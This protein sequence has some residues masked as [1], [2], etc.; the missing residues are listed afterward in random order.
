MRRRGR[1]LARRYGRGWFGF[2]PDVRSSPETQARDR[3]LPQIAAFLDRSGYVSPFANAGMLYD[4]G[5]SLDD[6]KRLAAAGRLIDF[7]VFRAS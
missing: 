1:A 6:V 2:G 4:S 7:G 3:V 5:K